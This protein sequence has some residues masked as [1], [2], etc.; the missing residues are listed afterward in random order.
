MLQTEAAVR[1]T[2][3]LAALAAASGLVLVVA[4]PVVGSSYYAVLALYAIFQLGCAAVLHS[5]AHRAVAADLAREFF[6]APGRA[7]TELWT[8]LVLLRE[9]RSS[10]FFPASSSAGARPTPQAVRRAGAF[11]ALGAAS[12]LLVLVH[13]A[14]E[15]QLRRGALLAAYAVL[16]LGCGAV[17]VSPA[18]R[19]V[20]DLA[21]RLASL[22]ANKIHG[23]SARA[24]T[25]LRWAG[26]AC[27]AFCYAA[28]DVRG[29]APA[30][31]VDNGLLLFPLFLVGVSTVYL[32]VLAASDP[33]PLPLWLPPPP[34]PPAA[35]AAAAAEE[36][37][38]GGEV[39]ITVPPAAS[40][41]VASK[42]TNFFSSEKMLACDFRIS[43]VSPL[44]IIERPPYQIT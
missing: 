37:H 16:L 3:A 5:P 2:G 22:T 30:E 40:G 29:A 10:R 1:R 43:F 44:I 13:A 18:H 21:R 12:V 17:L 6:V 23:A 8:A 20:A 33:P 14:V 34:P 31:K 42:R 36:G 25:V 19:A 4:P 26:F 24:E 9:K 28:A 38:D 41:A 35:A 11:A 7:A 39:N 27:V 32:S 15:E